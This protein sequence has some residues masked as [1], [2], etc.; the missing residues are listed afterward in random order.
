MLNLKRGYFLVGFLVILI[1]LMSGCVQQESLQIDPDTLPIGQDDTQEPLSDTQFLTGPPT[2]LALPFDVENM[3]GGNKFVSPFGLIRHNRD[4]GHG[5]AGID[6]PLSQGDSIYAVSDGEI[7]RNEPASDGPGNTIVLLIIKDREGEGW[8][9]LYEHINL[10]LGI[11]VGSQTSKGQSIGYSAL[12]KGN[13]HLGLVYYFND[14]QYT[15]EPKCWAEYVRNEDKQKLFNIWE[16]IRGNPTF[17]ESWQNAFEDG[18]YAYRALL[19]KDTFPSGPQL[20]YEYGLDVR[21]GRN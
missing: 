9:F 12:V 1:V 11:D 13:N 5:H 6:I 15:K 20:C 18:T 2:D 14:F 10:N 17:I 21:E 3:F 19:N 4:K 8:A 7:I 16:E